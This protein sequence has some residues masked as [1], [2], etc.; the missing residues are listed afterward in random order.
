MR[1]MREREQRP[2]VA[3]NLA[4]MAV[5]RVVRGHVLRLRLG[6]SSDPRLPLACQRAAANALAWRAGR[7]GSAQEPADAD[8]RAEST[9]LSLVARFLE[10][11]VRRGGSGAP[12]MEFNEWILLR[13]Q[14]WA[15]MVPW[16]AYRRALRDQYLNSAA[17]SIQSMWRAH[18]ATPG[19]EA[20]RSAGRKKRGVPSAGRAAFLIQRGWRGFTNKRI[21]AYLREMLYFREQGDAH[22]LLRGINPRE[23]ALI[24]AATAIHIRFRLGGELFPP[25]IFYKVY[26]HAPVTDV[27]AFAPRDYTASKQPPPIAMHN[28]ANPG[29]GRAEMRAAAAAHSGWYR[30][31][32]NNG[33][34]PVAGEALGDIN[35][36]A[37]TSLPIVWHHDKLVRKVEAQRKRKERK[38]EWLRTMYALGRGGEG[39]GEGSPPLGL[40]GEPPTVATFDGFGPEGEGDS[41]EELN[42]LLEWTDG[43]DYDSYHQ[44]WLALATSSRPEWT[45]ERAAPP[46]LVLP[47]ALAGSKGKA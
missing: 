16:R 35:T 30:R 21:F 11:R 43:L 32:E 3:F 18:A 41:D 28:H 8:A 19:G 45:T 13:L 22:E 10:T 26:T 31:V 36:T 42:A 4:A 25:A 34:R 15:R 40:L 27:G 7:G 24:D 12:D 38:R 23:A 1:L 6:N 37:R 17:R 39:G 5:Q 2:V 47:A 14:A 20:R 44:D 46:G 29:D 9:E 33:W